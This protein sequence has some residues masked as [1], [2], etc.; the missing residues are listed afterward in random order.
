MLSYWI[1]ASWNVRNHTSITTYIKVQHCWSPSSQW[2]WT[3]VF[4][5]N[6]RSALCALLEGVYICKEAFALLLLFCLKIQ[7]DS[8]KSKKHNKCSCFNEQLKNPPKGKPEKKDN[9]QCGKVRVLC[10]QQLTLPLPDI[11]IKVIFS[12]SMI[13]FF[14]F[15]FFFYILHWLFWH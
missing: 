15:S 4:V 10:L 5:D 9:T 14:H 3:S 7:D 2:D 1:T 13:L 8:S 11:N 12:Q 6:Y